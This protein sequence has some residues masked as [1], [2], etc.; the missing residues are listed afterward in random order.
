MTII[1]PSKCETKRQVQ[2]EQLINTDCWLT[3]GSHYVTRA[4]GQVGGPFVMVHEIF[5]VRQTR[6]QSLKDLRISEFIF[7]IA[8][9]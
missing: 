8:Y 5:K 6:S 3:V 9:Q 1:V 2:M 7:V 4:P